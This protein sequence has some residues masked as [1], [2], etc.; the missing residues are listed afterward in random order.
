MFGKIAILN[1]LRKHSMTML[2]VGVIAFAA[3]EMISLNR[4]LSQTQ[5]ELVAVEQKYQQVST[6]LHIL[7]ERVR[8]D[9]ENQQNIRER[10]S[11]SDLLLKNRVNEVVDTISK[12]PSG[13]DR[14]YREI[15]DR[16]ANL[17]ESI[18]NKG[19]RELSDEIKN[20]GTE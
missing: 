20:I 16:K 11:Q 9:I 13:D 8:E 12:S 19:T 7:N 1:F 5:T 2:M 14:D 10:F 4:S 6:E 15:M 17:L 3:Y 18:I